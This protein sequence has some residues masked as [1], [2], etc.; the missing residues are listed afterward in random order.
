[1]SYCGV[2]ALAGRVHITRPN[3]NTVTALLMPTWEACVRTNEQPTGHVDH[4][5]L[6]P[7]WE[8]VGFPRTEQAAVRAI[9]EH[10]VQRVAV[11]H[12]FTRA[13]V[14][15]LA[16]VEEVG[17]LAHEAQLNHQRRFRASWRLTEASVCGKASG[18]ESKHY[19]L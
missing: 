16:V 9:L 3:P 18:T 17:L 13:E 15:H 8:F 11:T 5:T 12:G 4:T 6:R 2:F 1:M 10:A 19:G 14:S 7:M